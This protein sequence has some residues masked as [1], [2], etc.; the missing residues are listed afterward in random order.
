MLRLRRH[1]RHPKK[2][3]VQGWQGCRLK[4]HPTDG[5]SSHRHCRHIGCRVTLGVVYKMARFP[6]L[7]RTVW[8]V[9]VETGTSVQN[10]TSV[11]SDTRGSVQNDTQE[12]NNIY[13]TTTTTKVLMKK[14]TTK[15]TTNPTTNRQQKDSKKTQTRMTRM[16]RI[17]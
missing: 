10:G 13:N 3:Y 8:T 11:Q 4:L 6:P 7:V 17:I 5:P 9:Q 12:I 2:G 15:T 16:K 14:P 1:N